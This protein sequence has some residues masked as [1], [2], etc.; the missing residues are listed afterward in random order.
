MGRVVHSENQETKRYKVQGS[1][2]K[3]QGKFRISNFEL[4]IL[5]FL[6]LRSQNPESRRYRA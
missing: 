6:K 4:R 1:G 3:V 5:K 2:Y